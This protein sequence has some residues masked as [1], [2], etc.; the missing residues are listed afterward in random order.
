METQFN[1]LLNT[2]AR[3]FTVEWQKAFMSAKPE[4]DSIYNL[5]QNIWWVV[6][7]RDIENKENTW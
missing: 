7:S 2:H 3:Q 1:E 5:I 6:Q 4:L